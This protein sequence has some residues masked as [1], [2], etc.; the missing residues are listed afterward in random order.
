MAYLPF[1]LD[2]LRILKAIADEGNFKRAAKS[3]YVSQPAVSLQIQSLEKQLNVPLFYRGNTKTQLT[4]TGYLVL[5]YGTRILALCEET[6]RA[7]EDVQNLQGGTLV[8]GASQTTGT[9]LLPRIIG[10]FRQRYPQIAVQLQVHSTRRIAWNVANGQVDI[11]IIG[12][13]VPVELEKVLDIIPYAEDELALILPKS[14]PFSNRLEIQ[15]EDLYQL[16]YITLDNQSTIRKVIDQVLNDNGIDSSRFKIEMELNSIESIKNAVQS[17][18]G[19]AFVSVSAIAK[20]LELGLLHWSKIENITIKRTLSVLTNPNRYSSKA[21]ETFSQ[22]ILT[23]FL[24]LPQYSKD[25][26]T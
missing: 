18:L 5:R 26:K 23:L 13:E 7:L 6:C 2:Q 16:R 9:Y 25:E 1:T 12:G 17:G 14:H 20:E 22:E 8:V 11:A 19:A 4:D 15:K 3:L 24:N 21:S 10:L